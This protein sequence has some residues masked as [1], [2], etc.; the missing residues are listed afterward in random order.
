MAA[1]LSRLIA[2]QR[3]GQAAAGV[4]LGCLARL[5]RAFGSGPAA[6]GPGPDT[7]AVPGII[8]PLTSTRASTR[9]PGSRG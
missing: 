2:A 6:P 4:P 5:Q 1:L 3:A 9:C 8:D 7:A